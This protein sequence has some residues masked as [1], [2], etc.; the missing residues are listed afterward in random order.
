MTIFAF[1]S[2]G[3]CTL[4]ASQPRPRTAMIAD[5][6][7]SIMNHDP[8]PGRHHGRV[9]CLVASLI[10]DSYYNIDVLFAHSTHHVLTFTIDAR[11]EN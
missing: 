11:C 3:R 10:R 1:H 7:Y 4:Q 2:Q 9:S 5:R 6:I 8:F